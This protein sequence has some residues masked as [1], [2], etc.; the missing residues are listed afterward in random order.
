MQDLARYAL[1][2]QSNGLVPIV[3]PDIVLQGTHTLHQA[4]EIAIRVQSALFDAM[5]AHGVYLPGA[6]L[7]P[8]MVNPGPH[9][10]TSYTVQEIAAANWYVLQ[11]SFPVAMPGVNFLS[12]GQDLVTAAA[13]LSA[14]N[15][16][17]TAQAQSSGKQQPPPW[18]LSFSWSQALQLPLLELCRREN[19]NNNNTDD[20]AKFKLPEMAALYLQELK[21]ASQAAQGT[22]QWKPGEGDH[23]GKKS[24]TSTDATTHDKKQS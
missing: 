4:V 19:N 22:Y 16:H 3:E 10:P 23:K 6:T 9:C 18:N 21:I 24:T 17:A 11:Q 20:D 13:R 2:C 12:G 14:M 5:R 8:N 7:K 15:Q 1:I